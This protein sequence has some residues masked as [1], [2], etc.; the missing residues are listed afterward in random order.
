MKDEGVFDALNLMQT[1]YSWN[2]YTLFIFL[3]LIPFTFFQW[4]C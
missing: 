2:Y 1:L 3:I 4:F